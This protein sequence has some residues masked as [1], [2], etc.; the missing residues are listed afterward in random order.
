MN[1]LSYFQRVSMYTPTRFWINNTTREEAAKAISAGATGCTHNPSYTWKMIS[2]ANEK[3]YVDEKL[4]DILKKE[5][6]AD[7]ALIALQRELVLG[8]ARSFYPMYEASCGKYGYVS[9]QGDPFH[10]D[11]QTII[12]CARYNCS[13]APNIM[14]KIPVTTDGLKAIGVLAAEGVPINATE[15]MAV[16]QAMDVCE[17]YAEAVR[18]LKNPAPILYSHITGIYD[19]YLQSYVEKNKI[20]ISG[21]VMRHAGIS[22]AKK[23]YRLTKAK[24]PQVGFIGGGARSLHH[25]S[26][27]VGADAVVTINWVGTADKLIDQ[28]LPV[29][30]SFNLQTPLWAEDELLEKLPDYRKGY[31]INAISAHEYEDFGP[32]VLFRSKFED[33]WKDALEYINK[34]MRE[35]I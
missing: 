18:D 22:I 35:L 10:E 27:M 15:V 9:I 6:D 14:A 12:E 21:D 34:R 7:N 31:Q 3:Q 17:V 25:F 30:E 20:D 29:I 23:T 28:N 32:V 8:I 26:D 33:D 1:E 24:Y 11:A 4:K 5:K 13:V 16:R 2:N 19:E